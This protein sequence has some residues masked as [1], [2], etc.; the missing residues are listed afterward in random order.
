MF[1]P[2]VLISMF[3]ASILALVLQCGTTAA[4]A[5]I[6]V[7][8]PTVGFGCRSLGYTIYAG[9]SIVILLLTIISTIS[10]RISETRSE[11]STVVKSFTASIAIALRRTCL[12]LACI[13]AVGLIVLSCFQ[14][15]HFLDNCYCN[16]SVIGRGTDSH[17]I[18]IYEG[19]T[20]TMRTAWISATTLAAAS[21]A[22]YMIY[23]WLIS[24]LPTEIDRL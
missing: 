14:F 1:P 6:I 2:G 13:N 21:M 5:I 10:A 15:T 16:A 3:N 12:L 17:L 18:I 20:S 4:A 11:H 8:T 22:I 7:F 24:A 19:W 9:I 23:L